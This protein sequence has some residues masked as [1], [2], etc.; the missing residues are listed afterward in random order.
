MISPNHSGFTPGEYSFN[1]L[2]D[3]THEIYKSFD[4][5][6]EVGEF[7]QIYQRLLV[8]Y[9]MKDYLPKYP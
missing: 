3:I 8:K 7:S 2:I 6:L 5:G 1:Q 4:D 9:V